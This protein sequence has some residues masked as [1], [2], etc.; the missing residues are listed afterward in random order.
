M[1]PREL[2]S[3]VI[4]N[5]PFVKIFSALSTGLQGSEVRSAVSAVTD[6]V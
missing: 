2:R 6:L 3:A 4:V 1:D 5:Q